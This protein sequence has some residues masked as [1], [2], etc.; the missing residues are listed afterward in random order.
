MTAAEL[1]AK[2]QA[3]DPNATVLLEEDGCDA[4]DDLDVYFK[5]DWDLYPVTFGIDPPI[6]V[7]L[8]TRFGGHEDMAKLLI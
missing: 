5:A 4:Y 1:I 6:P 8:L 3:I 2:L 7:V